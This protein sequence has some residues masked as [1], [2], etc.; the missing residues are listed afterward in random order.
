MI[1]I[2]WPERYP[3]LWVMGPYIRIFWARRSRSAPARPPAHP[4]VRLRLS[5]ARPPI[6][7]ACLRPRACAC[8]PVCARLHHP[9]HPTLY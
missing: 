6:V 2:D 4:R 1:A 8:L 5:P 9:H 7:C 3:P